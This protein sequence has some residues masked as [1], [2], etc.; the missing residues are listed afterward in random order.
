MD[1]IGYICPTVQIIYC[2]MA[3]GILWQFDNLPAPFWRFYR[4]ENEGAHI[5]F[6]EKKYTLRSDRFYL[7][8]PDTRIRTRSEK[9][10][11]QFYIHFRVSAP[12]DRAR[13]NVYEFPLPAEMDERIRQ[14]TGWL[15]G[16][17]GEEKKLALSLGAMQLALQAL[18]EFPAGE[19]ASRLRDPWLAGIDAYLEAHLAEPL[20]NEDLARFAHTNKN[21][22]IRRFGET[23]G[24]PPQTYLQRKRVEHA[25]LLLQ[26]TEL[27]LEEIAERTGFCDRHHFSRVFRK[28]REIGPAA[29]RN[30]A[31]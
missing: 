16:D 17:C 15:E 22:L 28:W 10:I 4:N 3:R 18:Q 2:K 11:N 8:P 24:L 7:L 20:H 14:L 1:D 19:L 31:T 5:L 27:T 23:C 25:C 30:K 29:Y 21:S 9:A 12:F 13:Q 6:E 26:M